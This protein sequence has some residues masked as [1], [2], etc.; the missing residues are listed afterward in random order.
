LRVWAEPFR[1]G[2]SQNNQ[3]FFAACCQKRSPSL[4]LRASWATDLG[5][6]QKSRFS[7]RLPLLPAHYHSRGVDLL[8]EPVEK[9]R[10]RVNI[11]QD[12]S[13]AFQAQRGREPVGH[14]RERQQRSGVEQA[15]NL[16]LTGRLV[17]VL[18]QV[19]AGAAL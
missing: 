2:R 5:S 19:F 12:R 8:P 4:L 16:C 6:Y 1:K 17:S 7:L 10:L 18:T 3:R 11:E 13:R 9:Q 15:L 14:H